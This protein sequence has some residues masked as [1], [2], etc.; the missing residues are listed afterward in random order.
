MDD[1]TALEPN[2]DLLIQQIREE[3]LHR[4]VGMDGQPLSRL[5]NPARAV[6]GSTFEALLREA[7]LD[8]T[9]Q[10]EPILSHLLGLS[11]PS[12]DASFRTRRGHVHHLKDLLS[13]DD[14][15]FIHAAYQTILGRGVDEDGMKCYLLMLREGATKVEILGKLQHSPE[16][17]HRGTRLEGLALAHALEKVSRWPVLGS[18]TAV[19]VAIW[20]LR[21]N[22][23]LQRRS[24]NEL[25]RR[26]AQHEERSALAIKTI[27]DALRNL[28][29]TQS[30]LAST[31][32]SL[33]KHKDLDAAQES[34]LRQFAELR[35][36]RRTM[37]PETER[38]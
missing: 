28:K 25:A 37:A 4:R 6:N 20:N 5:P 11:Y 24:T 38:R 26:I 21:R 36:L 10:R 27:D 15:A 1:P 16:G 17:K 32:K 29:E 2:V 7:K 13:Y 9:Q 12:R 34:L 3:V 30:L 31:T 8:N 23:R 35:F 22:Q 14:V 18:L 33:G 19:V